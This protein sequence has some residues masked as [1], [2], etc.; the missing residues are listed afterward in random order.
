[1]ST[2]L[3]SLASS[4][5][6]SSLN[7][8]SKPAGSKP[9]GGVTKVI[10]YLELLRDTTAKIKR[11]VYNGISNFFSFCLVVYFVK[12]RVFSVELPRKLNLYSYY[13]IILI[14]LF[15]LIIIDFAFVYF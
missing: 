4:L 8:K 12:F 1:M 6:L 5:Y 2:N 14:S 9:D 15:H 10:L 3:A 11:D 7:A 13:F